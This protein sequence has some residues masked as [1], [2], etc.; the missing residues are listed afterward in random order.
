MGAVSGLAN[1]LGEEV[2]RLYEL[3]KSGKVEEAKQLQLKLIK[4]SGTVS[5]ISLSLFFIIY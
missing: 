4:P 2:C 5:T 1:V 3:C